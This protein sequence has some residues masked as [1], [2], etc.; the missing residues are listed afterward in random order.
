MPSVRLREAAENDLYDI[1]LYT[2][3][4]WG[5]AQA[6]RYLTDL[7]DHFDALVTGEAFD[8]QVFDDT[9][10][11]RVS[12]CAHHFVFFERA[13]G[14]SVTILAVLHESMDLPQRLRERLDV[15]G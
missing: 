11:I 5:P 12:R 7:R 8:R 10:T 1:G 2:G 13:A 15:G 4:N 6:T 14:G 9:D 3:R